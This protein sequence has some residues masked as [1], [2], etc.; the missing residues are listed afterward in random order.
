MNCITKFFSED[1]INKIK[2]IIS[3]RY[4][5]LFKR[6]KNKKK[7]IHILTPLHGNMGD[8]A[9]VYATNK[10]FKDNFDDY[11][12][13]EI[14]RCDIYKYMKAIKKVV[15]P[16]DLIV[17]IGGGN[18]G[19]IWIDEER[20]RRFVIKNFPNNK[21]ISMPQT[22]SFTPDVDG[23]KEFL[24]TQEVYNKN[25]NLI[26]ISRENTSYNIMNENFKRKNVILN[27]D[28]VLY[29][30]NTIH[31]DKF[32]REYI[33]TCLRNDKE[34]VLGSNKEKVITDLKRDYGQVVE[35]DTV[36]NKTVIKEEREKELNKMFDK[37]LKAK[38]VITDRLHGMVFCAI[39]KTPCIVTKSLDHK[40]TGTYKWIKDLNYIRLVESIEF[41]NIKPIIEELN[42]IKEKNDINFKEMYFDK[43]T[44]TL[45]N[46]IKE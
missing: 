45:K 16:N 2:Y 12:I 30:N 5:N 24:N 7:I 31:D 22:I 19:N 13:I 3:F 25:K 46:I 4:Y 27:P 23:K 1:S 8:Q 41:E 21:I 17:L 20:D 35:F 11:E 14:Y 26:L 6:Y 44:S 38:V 18:M 39:T 42:N 28:T 37:F 32:K 15:N 40:V 43:L 9:I 10:Y 29:L 33:M 34:S 36:I